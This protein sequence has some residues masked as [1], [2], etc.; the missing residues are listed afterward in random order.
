MRYFRTIGK[1]LHGECMKAID[2]IIDAVKSN[3]T[4]LHIQDNRIGEKIDDVVSL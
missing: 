3:L 2:K 1:K 4:N